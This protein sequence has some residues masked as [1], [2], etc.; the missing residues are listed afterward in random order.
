MVVVVDCKLNTVS[1]QGE[2]L[3]V[4]QGRVPWGLALVVKEGE[5]VRRSLWRTHVVLVCSG[6]LS[7]AAVR[8]WAPHRA[9]VWG[10]REGDLTWHVGSAVLRSAAV[11]VPC[12]CVLGCTVCG[13]HCSSVC[14][15]WACLTSLAC[16]VHTA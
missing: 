5:G 9:E 7:D 6:V 1:H 8:S 4:R 12:V 2:I 13:G 10:F 16:Q 14:A 3:G 11:S 15:V